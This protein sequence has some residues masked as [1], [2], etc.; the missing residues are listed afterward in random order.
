MQ[1]IIE[2]LIKGCDNE[3]ASGGTM[4]AI[5]KWQMKDADKK[6][7]GELT[8]KIQQIEQVVKQNTDMKAN[9]E[10]FLKTL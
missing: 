5:Y 9:L 7:K 3:I 2:K 1:E 8:L 4:I 6:G 10:R